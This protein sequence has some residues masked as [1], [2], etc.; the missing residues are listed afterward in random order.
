VRLI[1]IEVSGVVESNRQLDILDSSA[2][3]WEQLDKA[4]DHIRDKYGFTA[5]QTGRSLPL[6]PPP[7]LVEVRLVGYDLLALHDWA[8][9]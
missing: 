3:H 4:V 7:P 1:G 6:K 9:R 2:W 8:R 5:I